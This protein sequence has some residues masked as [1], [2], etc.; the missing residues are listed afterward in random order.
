MTL[1]AVRPRRNV[2]T[3][4]RFRLTGSR[5]QWIEILWRNR[6]QSKNLYKRSWPKTHTGKREKE[7]LP[8]RKH[9]KRRGFLF[10]R[11][12]SKQILQH[13]WS[14]SIDGELIQVYTAC[15]WNCFCSLFFFFPFNVNLNCSSE[16]KLQIERYV[17]GEFICFSIIQLLGLRRFDLNYGQI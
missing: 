5:S 1:N 12:N 10:G 6:K 13:F 7:S 4:R 15:L 3:K 2:V 14:F 17:K 11:R 16:R 9:W 8:A